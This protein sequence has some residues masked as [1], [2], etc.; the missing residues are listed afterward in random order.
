VS[1]KLTYATLPA[2]P[3]PGVALHCSS[4]Q[5]D[6]SARRSD[7][8]THGA[9]NRPRCGCGTRLVLVQVSRRIIAA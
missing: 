4:C 2:E 1:R 7:Y 3:R 6:Y 8:F 5:A 9:E